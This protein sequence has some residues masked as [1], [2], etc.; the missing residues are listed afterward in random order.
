MS[1]NFLVLIIFER[2]LQIHQKII[3][4]ITI[5]KAFKFQVF[6]FKKYRVLQ[7]KLGKSESARFFASYGVRPNLLSG[8]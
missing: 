2:V 4:S 5:K 8:L 6:K 3:L 7:K 1:K